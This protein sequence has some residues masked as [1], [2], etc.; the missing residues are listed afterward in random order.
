MDG[1]R[2][3]WFMRTLWDSHV[4]VPNKPYIL[5]TISES[6]K[7]YDLKHQWVYLFRLKNTNYLHLNYTN[8][9]PQKTYYSFW[10]EY[11]STNTK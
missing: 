10:N 8:Q 3:G 5:K 11:T 9:Q 7:K 4:F 1:V 6:R 2:L